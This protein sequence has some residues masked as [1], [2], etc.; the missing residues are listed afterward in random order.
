MFLVVIFSLNRK[1]QDT[2]L[3]EKD[4][5]VLMVT[6]LNMSQQ[7]T[8]GAKKTSDVLGCIR[9][10]IASMVKEVFLPSCSVLV[11]PHL[12]SCAQCWAPQ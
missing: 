9:Q 1:K 6:K 2:V 5:G 7:C 11:K 3:A 4:L 12:E 10:R 8:F